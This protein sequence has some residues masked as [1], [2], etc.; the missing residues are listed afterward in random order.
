M[1]MR[2]PCSKSTTGNGGKLKRRKPK[3]TNILKAEYLAENR[4]MAG[5][6]H[7]KNIRYLIEICL[8]GTEWSL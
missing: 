5:Q 4:V 8:D 7:E 1:N 2:R 3:Y 6:P